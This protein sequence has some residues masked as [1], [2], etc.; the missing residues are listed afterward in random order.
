LNYKLSKVYL[1]LGILV[2]YGA[3]IVEWIWQ[4][5]SICWAWRHRLLSWW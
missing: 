2:I 3:H 4:R 1:S 5:K